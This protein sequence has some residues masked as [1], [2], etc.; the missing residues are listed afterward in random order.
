M[1]MF[2][3]DD[4]GS[5]YGSSYSYRS[6]NT[7]GG[8]AAEQGSRSNGGFCNSYSSGNRAVMGDADFGGYGG[9]APASSSS[10]TYITYETVH[11]VRGRMA[12]AGIGGG[13]GPHSGRSNSYRDQAY[14]DG[15]YGPE[16]EAE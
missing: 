7:C 3:K 6:G 15:R 13:G 4:G 10:V 14:Y 11:D 12:A 2:G 1:S 5:S 16:G 8:A 9:G